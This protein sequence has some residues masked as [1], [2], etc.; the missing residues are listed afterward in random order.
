MGDYKSGDAWDP[1]MMT[2]EKAQG[3]GG[4][5]GGGPAAPPVAKHRDDEFELGDVR[6]ADSHHYPRQRSS[7][8]PWFITLLVLALGAALAFFY[9]LPLD[10]RAK[11][12]NAELAAAQAENS[13]LVDK[14]GDLEKK[15]AELESSQA[16]LQSTVHEREAALAELTKTQDELAQKLQAEIQKGDVLIKQREGQLVVDLVDQI[17]FDSGAAELNEQGKAVLK[18]VGETFLKFPDKVIEVGG[19]TDNVPISP[20]LGSRFPSNWEL[21]TARATNVVRFLQDESKI[22]GQRL[23]AAGFSEF[24]P[25][26]S[27]KTATGR[28]RNRRI[29]V[30]LLPAAALQPS[31]KPAGKH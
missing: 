9:Y 23:V 15:R 26:G 18:K 19:H 1:T 14:L 25:T 11:Q 28:R 21:S 10:T 3:A 27:N 13:K 6:V 22:P 16:Q 30:V 5:R 29:E 12:I 31:A 24:R 2:G 7:R 20:K 8:V 17:M 4:E